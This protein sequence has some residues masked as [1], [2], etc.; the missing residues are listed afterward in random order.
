MSKDRF[1]ARLKESF[2]P[3]LRAAGFVGSGQNFRRIRGEAIHAVNLQGE[4]HGGGCAV[5]LGIHFTFMPLGWCE[6]LPNV[7]TIKEVDCEFRERLSANP[8]VDHWWTYGDAFIT[9]EE[10][11]DSLEQAFF[12]AG[13]AYFQNYGSVPAIL[14]AFDSMDFTEKWTAPFLGRMTRVR[15]ALA[16]ARVYE[17]LGRRCACRCF[18]EIGLRHLERGTGLRK[19]LERLANVV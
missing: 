8:E 11:A 6:D 14:T 9:P 5:N 10:S 15:A 19:E 16:A 4:R 2:T 18:A 3:R 13:E 1:Y 17:H 7:K 12:G